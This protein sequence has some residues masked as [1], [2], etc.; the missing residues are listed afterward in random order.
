MKSSP[1]YERSHAEVAPEPAWKERARREEAAREEARQI[2]KDR[3][4]VVK[5]LWI[6]PNARVQI[7]SD[8]KRHVLAW[9]MVDE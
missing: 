6:E 8:G 5:D 9:I 7:T 1:F 4:A 3:Y 2:A